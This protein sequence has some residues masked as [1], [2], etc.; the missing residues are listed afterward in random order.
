MKPFKAVGIDGW[1]AEELQALPFEAVRALTK[2]F[3]AIW[4]VGLSTHQM[5]ARVILLAKRNPPTSISDG[6][7]ITIL[8]YIS[9]LTSKLIADQLLHHWSLTWPSA[10]SGGLPFRGVEDI[11]FLQQ[12]QI[13]KA[14]KQDRARRGFTLDLIKA[15]DLLPRRVIYHL[16]QHHGALSESIDFGFSTCN[17]LPVTSKFVTAVR[18]LELR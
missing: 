13:E 16:L 6:R 2:I 3:A 9:R 8:G 10:I 17:A 11:T 18:A 5:I 12:F 14:K 4:P 7:R 15:F 1:G